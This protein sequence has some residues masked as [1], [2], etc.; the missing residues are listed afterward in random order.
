MLT[1]PDPGNN[2]TFND[3]GVSTIGHPYYRTEVGAH[4]NSD[5]HYGTFDQGG[6]VWEWNEAIVSGS[7]RGL[8]GGSYVAPVDRLLASFRASELP[9]FEHY[10][11]GF[12]VGSAVPEPGSFL[13]AGLGAMGIAGYRLRRR[14][15][16]SKAQD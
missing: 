1:D 10:D 9:T 3:S 16:R 13:L 14:E 2:A 15:R 4:E 12:R 7:S 11:V 5:S 6:N 8:R